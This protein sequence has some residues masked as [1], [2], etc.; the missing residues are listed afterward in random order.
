MKRTLH[1]LIAFAV[2]ALV[3]AT[4]CAAAGETPS[5]DSV[6]EAL[7][8]DFPH[9]QATSINE[10]AI[11]GLY[12]IE[13]GVNIVY[14]YPDKELL[15]FGEIWTKDG[16]NITAGKKTEIASAKLKDIPL[17]KAVRIGNGKNKVIEFTDP[18]CPYCRKASAFLKGRD[19]VTRY[20]FLF[21]L[22]LHKDAEAHALY[23][24]CAADKG[25]AL[26]EVMNGQLDGKA[27]PAC[28]DAKAE[29][30]LREHKD[31]GT[32][33]GVRGTPAFWINGQYVAGANIPAIEGILGRKVAQHTK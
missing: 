25:K 16:T 26:E 20:V 5:T 19:D 23:V 14:Y 18:D 15:V 10:T 1:T 8:K 31:L 2:F 13:A 29:A 9:L 17:D 7:K 11:R 3:I 27:L 24:L 21:P 30:L 12:E 22:P 32:T 4:G 6:R 28:S 33:L